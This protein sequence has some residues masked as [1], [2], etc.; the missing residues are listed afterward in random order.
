MSGKQINF[1]EDKQKLK[2]DFE[3]KIKHI[4]FNQDDITCFLHD[5]NDRI[6]KF[7]NT[8]H[9]IRNSNSIVNVPANAKTVQF[10]LADFF[11]H[12]F[13]HAMAVENAD[14]RLADFYRRLG[15]SVDF[16]S[17]ESYRTMDLLLDKRAHLPT[18]IQKLK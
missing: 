4:Y 9:K 15:E 13:S 7:L 2:T 12:F 16:I 11:E 5:I 6:S 17:N 1:G 8:L 3:S 10:L 14:F 18:P